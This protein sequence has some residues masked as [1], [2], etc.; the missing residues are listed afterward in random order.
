MRALF[1]YDNGNNASLSPKSAKMTDAETKY[2][3]T[4][5]NGASQAF[6]TPQPPSKS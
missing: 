5:Y 3:V 1:L 4:R 2:I 6:E